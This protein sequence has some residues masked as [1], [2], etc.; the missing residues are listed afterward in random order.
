MRDPL[1]DEFLDGAASSADAS[2]RRECLEQSERVMLADYPVAPLF[3]MV[4]KRMIK[5]YVRGV[6][7]NPLNHIRS[8]ALALEAR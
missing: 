5:P 4:A 7:L 6:V 1:F 3:F 2:R 8:Q